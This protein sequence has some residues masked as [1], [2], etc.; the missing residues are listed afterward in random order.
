[1][2]QSK[3]LFD[4][5]TM[6]FGEH[7][8][9]LRKHL[10]LALLG[11][12]LSVIVCLFFG[13]ELMGVIRYP[14]DKA[15]AKYGQ[16]VPEQQQFD[17]WQYISDWW[18][19]VKKPEE[20]P[21]Q[22]LPADTITV[23]VKAEELQKAW[24]NAFPQSEVP[25]IAE[26]D[27]ATPVELNL[28]SPMFVQLRETMKEVN[29]PKTFK[30]EEAFM[31]FIKVSF[32]FGLVFASPWVFYQLW[33]FVAA[34]LY[35]HE[36]RYVYIYLP[37]SIGLFL[38]G[39]IFCFY[40]VFPYVLD[41][42]LS[43][44]KELGVQAQIRLEEWISFALLLPLMFG[45][46][47]QLP[48]VMLFL[49]KINIFSATDYREKRRMAILVISFLSMILTPADP[50]SMILMAIPLVLLYEVGIILCK[51]TASASPFAAEA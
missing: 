15:L 35:P 21:K 1:M 14:I 17:L 3:D 43:F 7:L 4:D 19:G 30:V 47:F 45:I 8:E 10:I 42:L 50:M 37:M 24:K 6:S 44:N 2:P 11:L 29:R 36:K 49:D 32:V 22:E 51:R 46:S 41:F 26:G 5:S 34:G 38:G 16:V 20:P 28:S 31:T 9:A 39:A 12:V 18:N 23:Q 27:A 33:L 48:L 25:P 40:L 13:A